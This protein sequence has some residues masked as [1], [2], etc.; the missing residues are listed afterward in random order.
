MPPIHLSLQKEGSLQ[1][2]TSAIQNGASVNARLLREGM[3]IQTSAWYSKED[4]P[5]CLRKSRQSAS[6]VFFKLYRR[7]ASGLIFVFPKTMLE[8]R[9]V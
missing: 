8:F 4:T 2:I 9:R 5:F 7:S 1:Q 6:G 3:P